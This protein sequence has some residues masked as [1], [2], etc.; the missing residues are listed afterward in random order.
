MV[1]IL[2]IITECLVS[3]LTENDAK[4]IIICHNI[5]LQMTMMQRSARLSSIPEYRKSINNN[6]LY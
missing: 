4:V 1:R 5:S 6:Y 2:G 3:I